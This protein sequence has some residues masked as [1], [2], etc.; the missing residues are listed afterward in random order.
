MKK[1]V[2]AILLLLCVL[3]GACAAEQGSEPEPLM[4][5]YKTAKL[6]FSENGL[7]SGEESS[8]SADMLPDA[9]AERYFSGPQDPALVSPFPKGT[10][11]RYCTVSDRCLYLTLS[12]EFAEL[13]GA[14]RSLALSC[15]C[16][17]FMQLDGVESVEISVEQSP[18]KEQQPV[19]LTVME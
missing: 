19:R 17:T 6:S 3:L 8:G 12:G 2:I 14:D 11:L 9:L 4:L 18:L 16:A 1:R 5:Y 10:V 15:I 13:T 7:I